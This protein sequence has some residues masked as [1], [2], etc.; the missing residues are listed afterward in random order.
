MQQLQVHMSK[1]EQLQEFHGIV[2]LV[3]DCSRAHWQKSVNDSAVTGHEIS[4]RNRAMKLLLLRNTT[5]ER[6]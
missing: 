4:K 5:L 6:V 1:G 3:T 2:K